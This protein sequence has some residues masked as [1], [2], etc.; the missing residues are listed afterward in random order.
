[1]SASEKRTQREAAIIQ[2]TLTLLQEKGFMDLKM[3]EVAKHAQFSMGTVYSHFS[4]KEDLLLG[5]AIHISKTIASVFDQVIH[6]PSPPMERLLILNMAIWL[7]D[8]QQPHHYFLRQ[9]AMTPDIWQRASAERARALDDIYQTISQL[10]ESLI[11]ELMTENPTISEEN[12]ADALTDILMGIWSLGEG[13]FQISVSGFGLKQPSLQKD[14]GFGLLTTNLAKYLQGWGWQ[15]PFSESTI[16][17]SK[18]KAE[19][20]VARFTDQ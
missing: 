10:V 4:S 7:C 3:S 16:A 11:I 12:K 17:N 15:E 13:L 18:I 14:N 19:Q 20:T 8:A 1:M 9:L 5:C 6:S 2:A